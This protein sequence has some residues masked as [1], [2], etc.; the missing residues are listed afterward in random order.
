[1]VARLHRGDARTAFQD[2]ARRLVTRHDRH[3]RGPIAIHNVPVALADARRL[4][5]DAHFERFGR[6]ELALDDLQR[7]VRL[8]QDGGFHDFSSQIADRL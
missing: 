7:L 2:L 6:V 3:R 5:L 1:M 8:E 4:H